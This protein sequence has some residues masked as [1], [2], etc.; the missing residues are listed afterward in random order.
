MHRIEIARKGSLAALAV[1]GMVTLGLPSGT[2]AEAAAQAASPG[3]HIVTYNVCG[4]SCTRRLSVDDWNG[5]IIHAIEHAD[6]DVILLQELCR[7]QYDGLRR[8][9]GDRYES[10]WAGTMSDNMGCGD[11]WS[12][13]L[14]DSEAESFGI[15]IFIRGSGSIGNTQ[16]LWLPN[17][18]EDEP[19]ALLCV[20][21]RLRGRVARVCN[22]HLDWHSDT[23]EVQAAYIAGRVV[24][25]ARRMPVVFGGDMNAVPTSTAMGYFY[26]RSAGGGTFT[27][28]DD[29]DR[30]FFGKRCG[31]HAQHCRSGEE[32]DAGRK[33]DYI[34]LSRRHFDAVT[35]DA[36]R[37]DDDL[38]DHRLLRGTASWRSEPPL[39]RTQRR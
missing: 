20:D 13:G 15:A 3:P 26:G 7:G 29:A 38:S 34:F 33:I 19:R 30:N 32:T 2:G 17:Q 16:R 21:A 23:E 5:K 10:R 25:W 28:V 18:E 31:K 9:L 24:P 11:Q 1:I 36:A 22:S 8:A 27:E 35:G 39:A 6:A 14:S 37:R 12:D 4:G